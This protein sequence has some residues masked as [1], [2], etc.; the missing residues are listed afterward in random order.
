MG[1]RTTNHVGNYNNGEEVDNDQ[2]VGK[3]R[4]EPHE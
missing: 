1:I 4:R 2:G 3:W